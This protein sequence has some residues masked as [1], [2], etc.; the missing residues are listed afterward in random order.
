MSLLQARKQ[1]TRT[2]NL[3]STVH[4]TTQQEKARQNARKAPNTQSLEQQ[5]IGRITQAY[6]AI[7]KLVEK[8]RLEATRI[9]HNS[10][11]PASKKQPAGLAGAADI[12]APKPTQDKLQQIADQCIRQ[13]AAY[14]TWELQQLLATR[15]NLTTAIAAERVQQLQ[16][17]GILEYTLAGT[18]YLSHSTPF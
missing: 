2:L 6:P 11:Q 15:L 4:T 10:P 1:P 7:Q 13:Q 12:P 14:H 17:A 9:H 8:L 18:L 16:Q 3:C 5:A